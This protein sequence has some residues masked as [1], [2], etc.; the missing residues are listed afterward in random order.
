MQKSPIQRGLR[1]GVVCLAIVA[2]ALTSTG[3]LGNGEDMQPAPGCST[4]PVPEPSMWVGLVLLLSCC[5][6]AA[7]R[8]KRNAN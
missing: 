5:L 8:P 4:M 6:F 1:L 3:V 7:L 2:L